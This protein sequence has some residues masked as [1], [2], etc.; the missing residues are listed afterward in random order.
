MSDPGSGPLEFD[1]A[2]MRS[3]LDELD[4]RL[5]A[6]GMAASVYVVGGAAMALAYGR[7]GVTP[8]IDAVAS[9]QAVFE[10]AR[11][12]ADE[13]GL[14]EDWLNSAAA[15]S[16]PSPPPFARRRP[17]EPGLAVHIAPPEHVLAMKLVSLR[18]KDR[19][20]IRLLIEQL[21][22]AEA[23]GEDYAGLLS[24]VYAGEGRLSMALN[25]P[26]DDEQAT[27]REALAIGAWAHDFAASLRD[28]VGAVG[29][30]ALL[31]HGG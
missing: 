31:Q 30:P 14:A 20:D 18:R 25:I 8:D 9:H 22:M 11:A 1:A 5:R 6:R 26:G 3:L 17:T 27:R 12:M 7:A 28:A 21:G 23:T 19:P 10:E 15:G 29:K 13:H 16:V 2:A 4:G 24:R